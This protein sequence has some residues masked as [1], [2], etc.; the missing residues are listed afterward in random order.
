MEHG[1]RLG[2]LKILLMLAW[3]ML[4]QLAFW[5]FIEILN[6]SRCA[7]CSMHLCMHIFGLFFE[8]GVLYLLLVWVELGCR[9]RIVLL[10]IG[11]I[12]FKI[13]AQRSIINAFHQNSNTFVELGTFF[14]KTIIRSWFLQRFNS[15]YGQMSTTYFCLIL[16]TIVA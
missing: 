8:V 3:N 9:C 13:G 10:H 12:S 4:M 7:L 11:K 15:H 14:F 1:V 5:F 6:A 16:E 2:F